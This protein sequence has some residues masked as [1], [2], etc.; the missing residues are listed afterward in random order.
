MTV[1]CQNATAQHCTSERE[2]MKLE[3]CFISEDK[4]LILVI[5]SFH[6]FHVQ[7]VALCLPST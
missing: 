6:Q 3:Q 1:S 2:R 7:G 5:K 4:H